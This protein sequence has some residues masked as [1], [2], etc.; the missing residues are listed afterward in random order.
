MRM[1]AWTSMPASLSA[2]ALRKARQALAVIG[3]SL[4]LLAVWYLSTRD[5]GATRLLFPAPAEVARSAYVGI[6]SGELSRHLLVTLYEILAGF[7]IGSA[8]GF[9]LGLMIAE[10]RLL[11]VVLYPYIIAFQT[12]PKVAIAPLFVI[13]FGFG[14]ESKVAITATIVFFP[15]LAN[16]MLG[17][18]SAP[19]EQIE[20][21][22][23]ADASRWQIV[24]LSRLPYALPSVF[25]GLDI[26][27]VLAVIGAIVGEFVGAQSGLG[28]L[29][30]QKNFAMD[31]GAA[32]AILGLLSLIGFVLHKLV[33]VVGAQV[34]FWT[35][36]N[37]RSHSI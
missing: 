20:L 37:A 9:V 21:L 33:A 18:R 16:T 19:L 14:I 34:N 23:A 35:V 12:L 8:V 30:L 27:I 24:C 31:S 15:V 10:I 36:S 13:W 22:M 28:Y 1:E 2:A 25:A 4:V 6:A 17:L 26:A 32:F 3:S 5:T 7:A 29:L 11:E